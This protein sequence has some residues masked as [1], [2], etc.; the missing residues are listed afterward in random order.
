MGSRMTL[1]EKQWLQGRVSQEFGPVLN[2][3]RDRLLPLTQKITDKLYRISGLA[4]AEKEILQAVKKIQRLNAQFKEASGVE[5]IEIQVKP[6]PGK[7]PTYG[8]Y[9]GADRWADTPFVREVQ[10]QVKATKEA[11][12]LVEAEDKCRQLEDRVMLAGFPEQL[13]DL[14]EKELPRITGQYAKLL[15]NGNGHH[16]L[17]A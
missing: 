2:G 17:G 10:A 16:Q 13:V 3:L 12:H 1:T 11:R 14:I 5:C 7:V 9:S 15:T 8:A 6:G 4:Q